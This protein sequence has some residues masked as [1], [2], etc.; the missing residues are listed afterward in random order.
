MSDLQVT[1]F[2]IQNKTLPK[3]IS[4]SEQ[5]LKD[6]RGDEIIGIIVILFCF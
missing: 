3:I 6:Q 5:A 2:S 4:V 1:N